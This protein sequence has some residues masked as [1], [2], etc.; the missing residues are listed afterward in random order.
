[1]AKESQRSASLPEA[2]Q[3]VP[4]PVQPQLLSLESGL[5]R[6]CTDFVSDH[7]DTAWGPRPEVA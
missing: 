3:S 7:D 5:A 4:E 2:G 1:V 6:N